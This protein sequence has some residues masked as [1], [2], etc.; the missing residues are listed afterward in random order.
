VVITI[1]GEP[2]LHNLGT[3]ALRVDV[4]LPPKANEPAPTPMSEAQPAAAPAKPLSRLEMLRM[5][6][7]EKAKKAAK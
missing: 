3:G 1:N 5:E 7:A 6:Q 2:I 4:P